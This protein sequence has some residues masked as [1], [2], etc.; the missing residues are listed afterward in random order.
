M[1]IKKQAVLS[2]IIAA[3]CGCNEGKETTVYVDENGKEIKR[4]P[5][6]PVVTT[7][8]LRVIGVWNQAQ[9]YMYSSC[10]ELLFSNNTSCYK[11]APSLFLRTIERGD[12]VIVEIK[13]GQVIS[14]IRN[15]TQEE[16]AREFN[17]RKR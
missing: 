8:T 12:I 17:N 9:S 13:D 3:E 2:G 4:E 14:V 16:M 10:T 6:T 11:Y 15:L 1:K 7:D 5:N